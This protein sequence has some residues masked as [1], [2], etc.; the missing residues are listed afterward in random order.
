[1]QS[2]KVTSRTYGVKRVILL[3]L[4]FIMIGSL[5]ELYLL[6]HYEDTLQFIPIFFIGIGLINLFVL[7]FQKSKLLKSLFKW[8]LIL[9]SLSGFY[10]VFLHLQANYEFEQE[11]KPTANFG[12]LFLESLSGALPTLAPLSM[13][14]LALIGYSYLI[15]TH[16]KNEKI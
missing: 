5:L 12:D 2:N 7:F 6:D 14:V 16:K 15:L 11:M 1:M 9:I 13:V 3:A 8:I 10:G 4:L